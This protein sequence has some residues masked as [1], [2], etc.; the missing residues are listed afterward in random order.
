[1]SVRRLLHRL[2][3]LPV[4]VGYYRGP[5]LMSDLRKAWVRFRNPDVTIVFGRHT[6]LGPGFSLHAPYG[7]SFVTGRRVEFRRGY[8]AELSGPE[9]SIRFGDDC[10]CTYDVIMQCGRVIHVGDRVMFGQS[11]LVVDGN[12]RYRDLDVPMLQQGYDYRPVHIEDDATITTKCTIIAPIGQRAFVGA[13]TLVTRPVRAFTVVGGVPARELEY[14][15]P[16]PAYSEA[17]SDRSG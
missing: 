4:S 13:N 16:E 9:S 14:F 3:R 6:Y 1:M 10:V 11:T 17:N 15:G 5:I 12:H 8:R 2:R 7:G